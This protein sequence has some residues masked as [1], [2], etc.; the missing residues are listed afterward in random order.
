MRIERLLLENIASFKGKTE[1]HFDEIS[2][3]SDLFAIT[4]PTGSGK[5]TI[6]TSI[7]MALFGV[8]PR[9]LNSADI[10]S[11]GKSNGRIECDFHSR[12]K[13]YTAEWTCSVLKKNGEPRKTPL[14]TRILLDNHGAIEETIEDLIGLT[15]DQF[16][17][18]VI[19]NQGQFSTFLTSSFTERKDLLEKL[20]EHHDLK[21]LAR[22]LKNKISNLEK[23]KENGKV[24][25]E[26]MKFLQ[27]DEVKNKKEEL[28]N[29][30]S[31]NLIAET[32]LN[33]LD[34]IQERL[35]SSIEG[36]IKKNE[37]TEKIK[38]VS[39][40]ADILSIEVN[41]KKTPL[42]EKKKDLLNLKNTLKRET[43]LL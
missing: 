5:S 24:L 30:T 22:F 29:L 42:E 4:G 37:I 27:E 36:E 2:N 7:S 9:G 12:G 14:I 25:T 28:K 38:K 21:V 15:F 10:V 18:V 8:H 19:L 16:S 39:K 43:P 26:S 31:E 34:I 17:K 3:Q 33:K 11:M 6:L 41:S 23:E 35:K 1:I 32:F 13:R 20:L 40:E